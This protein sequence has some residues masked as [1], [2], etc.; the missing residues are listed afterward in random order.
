[1]F[2]VAPLDS[3]NKLMIALVLNAMRNVQLVQVALFVLLVLKDKFYKKEYA[4]ITVLKD[5]IMIIQ[6]VLSAQ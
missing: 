6:L 3:I 1:M 4:K 2:Q 5:S